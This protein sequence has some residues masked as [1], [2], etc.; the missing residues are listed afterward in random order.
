MRLAALLLSARFTRG[1]EKTDRLATYPQ[2]ASFL[3]QSSLI[4][5]KER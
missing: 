3:G 2:C 4:V 5:E 1:N